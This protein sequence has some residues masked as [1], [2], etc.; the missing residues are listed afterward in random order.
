MQF[1][2]ST[3]DD[4]KK[5]CLTIKRSYPR[6]LTY[7]R[8]WLVCHELRPRRKTTRRNLRA[9]LI[10]KRMT[11][12]LRKAQH[13]QVQCRDVSILSSSRDTYTS[14]QGIDVDEYV[15]VYLTVGWRLFQVRDESQQIVLCAW[16]HTMKIPSIRWNARKH[17]V[18]MVHVQ[19]RRP[20][21]RSRELLAVGRCGIL[22]SVLFWFEIQLY[23]AYWRSRKRFPFMKGCDISLKLRMFQ[24]LPIFFQYT[25]KKSAIQTRN[26]SISLWHRPYNKGNQ[27]RQGPTI[28]YWP[29][30]RYILRSF[31]SEIEERGY[32]NHLVN[33][34]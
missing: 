34:V 1:P 22:Q 8:S 24:P 27:L 13:T 30:V 31:V 3:C 21:T 10:N 19:V 12:L 15:D 18:D 28:L 16:V 33:L 23:F 9:R 5:L 11:R 25:K 6:L 2:S 14:R 17:E 26:R 4:V 29:E 7:C 32:K 20:Q